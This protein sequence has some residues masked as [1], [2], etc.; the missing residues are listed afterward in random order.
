MHCACRNRLTRQRKERLVPSSGYYL[1][2]REFQDR[3][4]GWLVILMVGELP[5]PRHP[6]NQGH[7]GGCNSKPL[8]WYTVQ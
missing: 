3:F 5:L 8:R 6:A 1:I 2:Y 7:R 4:I